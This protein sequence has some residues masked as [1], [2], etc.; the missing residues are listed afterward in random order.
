MLNETSEFQNPE[1]CLQSCSKFCE[2]TFKGTGR[3]GLSLRRAMG[4]WGK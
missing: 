2:I 1:K 3:P 4:P